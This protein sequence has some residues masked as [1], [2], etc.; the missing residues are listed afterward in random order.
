MSLSTHSKDQ[1]I[2][3]CCMRILIVSRII[4]PIY[5]LGGLF[6]FF[7]IRFVL[8][9]WTSS[10]FDIFATGTFGLRDK[11]E[12]VRLN[13]FEYSSVNQTTASSAVSNSST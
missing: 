2:V 4:V 7:M 5:K 3:L 9:K 6:N 13:H 1:L 10:T 8:K 12:T 11:E